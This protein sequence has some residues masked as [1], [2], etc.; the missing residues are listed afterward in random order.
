MKIKF[1]KHKPAIHRNRHEYELWDLRQEFEKL[2]A[3]DLVH[4]VARSYKQQKVYYSAC[5]IAKQ[6]I[7]KLKDSD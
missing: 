7:N 1:S 6:R 3:Q 2:L 4:E 5:I